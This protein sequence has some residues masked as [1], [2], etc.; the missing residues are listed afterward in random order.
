MTVTHTYLSSEG[1]S[2]RVEEL[3]DQATRDQQTP[4]SGP[5]SGPGSSA[6]VCAGVG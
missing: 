2:L 3:Q 6:G 4:G 1:P 5:V